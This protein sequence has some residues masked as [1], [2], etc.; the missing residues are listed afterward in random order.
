[1][2]ESTKRK[3]HHDKDKYYKCEFFEWWKS[4]LLGIPTL[5]ALKISHTVLLFSVSFY[6]TLT[7]AKEQGFRSRAAFKLTQ[8]NRKFPYLEKCETAVLDLCAA[9]GGWTQVAARTCPKTAQIVAV[10]ILPIRAMKGFPNITTLIGDIT[11]DKCKADIKN[12]IAGKQV[13]LVLHD[14]APN[15]GADYAKDAYEQNEIALHALRCAT[16]HLKRGGTF[17]TKIYR[18]RDYAS[19]HWLLQQLFQTVSAFKPKASRQQSA[20]IFL[21]AENYKAPAKLDPRL[22]DP[23]H[24]FEAVDGQTTG[25]DGSTATVNVMSK[26]WDS[27]LKQRRRSGY[28]MEHLDATMRHI[29]P[30]VEF[31]KADMKKAVQMLSTSTGFGFTSSESPEQDE[32]CKWLLHHPLTTD[33]IKA[34]ASDLQLLNKSDFKALLNWRTKMQQAI[35]AREESKDEKDDDDEDN[36]TDGDEEEDIDSDKEEEQIQGEIEEMRQRRLREK[37][38]KKKKERAVAA[39]R[40]RQAALGMDLNAIDVPDHDKLFSLTMITNAGDLAAASEVNLDKVTDEQIFGNDNEDIV[41][42]G[43]DSGKDGKE[44]PED[45]DQAERMRRREEDLERAYHEYLKNTKDGAAKSGTKMAKRSKKAQRQKMAE[46]AVEDA[47]MM[48]AGPMGIGQDTKAYV[49]L[50]QGENASDEES[51]GQSSEDESDDGFN[52]EPMTPDQHAALIDKRNS[53]TAKTNPLLHKFDEESASART[54]RWFSNPLFENIAKTGNNESEDDDNEISANYS[55]GSSDSESDEHIATEASSNKSKKRKIGLD[56]DEILD[57]IPKTDKQIRHEKRLKQMARDERKK[58]RRAKKL[59]EQEEDFEIAP[60]DNENEDV[61]AV[62]EQLAGLSEAKRNKILAARE[63]I[64]QGFGKTVHTSEDDDTGF[65]VV[66]QEDTKI[67]NRPLPIKD[68]RKYDS[69]NEDYDSDDYAETLALGTMILRRSK[70][71]AL[72]DASYNRYAWNDPAG[73]PEWFVDDEKKF[74]RPQLPIPPALLAKMKE[75]QMA[76]AAK[77]IAKVAEA[78]ARKTRRAHM[79]LA[80]AKKQAESIANSSELS[81]SMKL[82]AIS[83]A[84]RGQPTKRPGKTYVVARKGGGKVGGKNVKVVD[85]RMK[86]DKRGME[87]A[88]KRKGK[89]RRR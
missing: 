83:K 58:A 34:S 66:S 57:M 63:Q 49:K 46:E 10:D 53:V 13:D 25:A 39:K 8:I 81:E 79:K 2:V 31:V 73:L 16:Q 56:A 54:A 61:D 1:M 17:I 64:R 48:L 55:E 82:K 7:V 4:A 21:V 59:G 37:K 47:E 68:D 11:T 86:S 35:V 22:L 45:L 80:A 72:V 76:L 20:E 27:K 24:I 70:E 28:D 74:Y 75:K 77:P 62:D 41:I 44:E 52:A 67:S 9:P 38:R 23:K 71:K 6:G 18:S 85:K 43:K 30:I 42:G 84:L 36:D 89:K 65:Q 78:R 3:K 69:A 12:A 5:C 29:E 19:Y 50:L 14:G 60:A 40:R 88:E 87:R 32:M 15:V 33:E 51:N 26:K